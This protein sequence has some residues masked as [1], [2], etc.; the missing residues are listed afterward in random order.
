[1]LTGVGSGRDLLSYV[2]GA[3][4]DSGL[5]TGWS[6]DEPPDGEMWLPGRL[7]WLVTD[8]GAKRQGDT[9]PVGVGGSHDLVVCGSEGPS[10]STSMV[11]EPDD[12]GT[13]GGPWLSRL[14][15]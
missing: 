7:N 3:F 11:E 15:S 12:D 6:S 8:D 10:A 9:G 2:S 14:R 13:G 1:M 4:G 5:A